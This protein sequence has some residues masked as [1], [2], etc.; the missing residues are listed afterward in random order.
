MKDRNRRK[1]D[2]ARQVQ[3]GAE[4]FY[5]KLTLPQQMVR[6]L[7]H[8]AYVRSWDVVIWYME[9]LLYEPSCLKQFQVSET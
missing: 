7:P 1:K 8:I 4:S 9:R 3:P 5:H 6:R 2:C